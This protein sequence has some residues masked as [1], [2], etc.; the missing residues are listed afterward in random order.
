MGDHIRP[1]TFYFI[2]FY[3][4]FSEAVTLIHHLKYLSSVVPTTSPSTMQP[5][6][7]PSLSPN[8]AFVITTI[9]GA[10]SPSFSGDGGAVTSAGL[11]QPHGVGLDS[12]G[13]SILQVG[14]I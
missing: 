3:I 12:T 14:F 7:T 10:G 6:V 5:S 4:T 8:T 9:A 2:N 13:D 1:G 11:N